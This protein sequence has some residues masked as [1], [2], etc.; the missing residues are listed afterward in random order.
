MVTSKGPPWHGYLGPSPNHLVPQA[1]ALLAKEHCC[2]LPALMKWV[3][4][5]AGR[6]GWR[7]LALLLLRRCAPPAG[8]CMA[9]GPPGLPLAEGGGRS[10]YSSP[11]RSLGSAPSTWL[12]Y[13]SDPARQNT[14]HTPCP[15]HASQELHSPGTAHPP[16]RKPG[17][18][19][20][21]ESRRCTAKGASHCQASS[22]TPRNAQAVGAVPPPGTHLQQ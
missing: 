6:C 4:P 9:W 13:R 15:C 8:A 11:E 12:P 14:R 16:P 2:S 19:G 5:S 22:H 18:D 7:P 3:K 21:T 1:S 10:P 20:P 17:H